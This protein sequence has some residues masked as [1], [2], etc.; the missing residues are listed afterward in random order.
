[1]DCNS[2][3]DIGYEGLASRALVRIKNNS[4]Q[5][6]HIYPLNVNGQ[7]A[8]KPSQV[9]EPNQQ[10]DLKTFLYSPFAVTDQNENCLG[11]YE[12]SP[13]AGLIVIQ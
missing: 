8:E 12:P 4:G 13:E 9:I 6:I 7:R 11:V 10:F 2:E 3:A 1:M 5:P